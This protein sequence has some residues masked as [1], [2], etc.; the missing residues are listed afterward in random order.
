[1]ISR[2][3]LSPFHV[4]LNIYVQ[5]T[6]L[7]SFRMVAVSYFMFSVVHQTR[8]DIKRLQTYRQMGIK[9]LATADV[10]ECLRARRLNNMNQRTALNTVLNYIQVNFFVIHLVLMHF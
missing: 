5:I 3:S 7:L 4:C 8:N 1:M 10:Y 6:I 2:N 9:H